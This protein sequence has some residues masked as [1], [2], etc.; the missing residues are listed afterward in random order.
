[1]QKQW[2]FFFLLTMAAVVLVAQQV[3]GRGFRFTAQDDPD[4]TAV[5]DPLPQ[6]WLGAD[7]SVSFPFANDTYMWL[8]GD[9]LYGNLAKRGNS[10]YRNMSAMPHSSLAFVDMSGSKK[11]Q[12]WIRPSSPNSNTPDSMGLFR[13]QNPTN[14][15]EY[16]WTVVGMMAPTTGILVVVAQVIIATNSGIGFQQLGTDVILVANPFSPP[17]Q[18]KYLTSRVET[19]SEGLSWNSGIAFGNGYFYFIG[20]GG[21]NAFLARITEN[22]LMN[23]NWTGLSFWSHGGVWLANVSDLLPL[24]DSTY[25]EGTLQYHPY[26]QQW[27]LILAQ[28]YESD[29]YIAYAPEITGPW[30]KVPIYPYPK[31]YQNSSFITYSGKSHPEYAAEN[32]I[33]FTFN[34]NS[35]SLAFVLTDLD[36]YHPHFVRVTIDKK[37]F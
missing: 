31:Q 16:Y 5:F 10:L 34:I 8:W 4:L 36:I 13:P 23:F 1:M 37:P 21:P 11:P 35:P 26:M 2:S 15:A 29:V 17:E 12:Y 33:V 32:E 7:V 18:W 22:D 9:T 30:T 20:L 28:A 6:G 19:S 3:E 14:P 25:T 27:F 24:Y